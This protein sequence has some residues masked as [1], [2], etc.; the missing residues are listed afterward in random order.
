MSVTIKDVAERAG[1]SVATASRALSGGRGV[2]PAN[3][4]RVLRAA[5]E[6][7]YE[8]NAVA[9]ALRSR[10]TNSI[11]IVVPRISNPFFATLVE[12]VEREAARGGRGLLLAASQYDPR[13]EE[14][15]L[16]S[17]LDRRVDALIAVPCHREHSRAAIEAAGRRV[18]TVQLDLC[19]DGGGGSWVGVD[20]EAGILAA[21]EH[22]V[23]AGACTLA[24][25]GSEPTDSSAQARLDGFRG[26]APLCPG[27][28]E[29]VLL[30]DFSLDWGHTAARRLLERPGA[31]PEGVVC[32]NDTIALGVLRELARG[33]VDVPGRVM[34][35][36]FDDIPF[37][38]LAEPPLTTVRQPQEQLASEAVRTLTDRLGGEAEPHRRIAIAPE[39]VVRGT[40]RS[41]G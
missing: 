27:G 9:A 32:G 35:T 7:D 8:P 4:E 31:L 3:R 19:L 13:V 6:L 34:V 41:A 23:A 21:V 1:V 2:R 12:A 37:A 18:P 5:R 39:L 28:T 22:L 30:G 25:V 17:L 40:T 26:A 24:Y 16:R 10:T 33:G 14:A 20:S 15:Q 38:E 11:G 29:R 36:G